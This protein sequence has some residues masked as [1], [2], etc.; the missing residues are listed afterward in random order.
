MTRS[1]LVSLAFIAFT[2]GSCTPPSAS[3]LIAWAHDMP[4]PIKWKSPASSKVSDCLVDLQRRISTE[5]LREILHT[6]S[7]LMGIE[8][9]LRPFRLKPLNPKLP[10]PS[11]S[12]SKC[13]HSLE[14][15]WWPSCSAESCQLLLVLLLALR[16][17]SRLLLTLLPTFNEPHT[18]I[19]HHSRV[20]RG[21]WQSSELT[22]ARLRNTD[23]KFAK[24]T[25]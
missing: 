5:H 9:L 10:E 13:Q 8:C 23:S 12:A 2:C 1:R 4:W 18:T 7:N 15:S 3:L 11:T 22:E 24:A 20:P 17:S 6:S 21:K 14:R 19:L 16:R 25:F